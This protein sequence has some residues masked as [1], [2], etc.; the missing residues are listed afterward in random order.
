MKKLL[1]K[2]F[3]ESISYYN[4]CNDEEKINNLV[5]GLIEK[6][7]EEIYESWTL[8]TLL[9]FSFV[10]VGDLVKYFFQDS[11]DEDDREEA[12]NFIKNKITKR[13]KLKEMWN[14]INEIKQE[15]AKL[16]IEEGVSG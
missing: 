8:Y 9:F 4:C 3:D 5:N 16:Q 10:V 12:I 11:L 13:Y 2:A 14:V 15:L 1:Q 6:F 7:P